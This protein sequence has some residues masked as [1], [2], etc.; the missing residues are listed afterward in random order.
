MQMQSRGI[1]YPQDFSIEILP[2]VKPEPQSEY[3]EVPHKAWTL[4]KDKLD[5]V[6]RRISYIRPDYLFVLAPLH[7][8]KVFFDEPFVI[9]THEDCFVENE[10]LFASDDVCSEEYSYEMLIPY[11]NAYLPNTKSTAF[12]APGDSEKI[13]DFISYLK[14]NYPNSVFIVSNNCTKGIN[15][16]QMWLQA[17]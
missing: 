11:I 8:G 9:Y 15:C 17:L 10:I 12:Y 1:I 4:C 13:K 7:K 16:S 2:P 14:K 3:F 6:F 5:F